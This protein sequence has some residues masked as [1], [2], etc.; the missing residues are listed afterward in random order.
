MKLIYTSIIVLMTTISYSQGIEIF[1]TGETTDVSGTEVI[2]ADNTG[3]QAEMSQW[4]DI[5]DTTLATLDLGIIRIKLEEMAGGVQDY[6]CFGNGVTG[7]CY[8]ENAVS[9]NDPYICPDYYEFPATVVPDAFKSAYKPNGIQGTSKYRYYF[10]DNNTQ[11]KRDSIDVTYTNTLSAEENN[12]D[13]SVYPNPVNDVLNISISENNTSISIFDI[14]G[15][16]VSNMSLVNGKNSL[17]IEN[18]NPGVYFYSIKR[19]GNII[20]TK[21][22]IVR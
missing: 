21:K 4:F 6:L 19:N 8:S 13:F 17:N 2:V 7:E 12:I 20:E 1:K 3:A 14:V 10:V 15:K 16:N 9:P 11:I 18:L 5:K 22:L